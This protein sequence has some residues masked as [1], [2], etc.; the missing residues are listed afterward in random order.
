MGVLVRLRKK[1]KK[2]ELHGG[3]RVLRVA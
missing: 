1:R 3:K 2:K